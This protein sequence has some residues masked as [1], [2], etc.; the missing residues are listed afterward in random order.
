MCMICVEF[1]KAR[2]TT[3]EARR[4]LG[5]MIEGLDPEHIDEVE[6]LLT[7]AEEEEALQKDQ[8]DDD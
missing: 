8:D 2:M 3:T 7:R 5:E 4:A 6:E 1:Q